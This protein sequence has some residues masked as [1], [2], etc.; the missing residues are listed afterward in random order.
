MFTFTDRYTFEW[1][2]R[3]KLPTADGEI[4]QEFTGE[5]LMPDDETDIFARV[6]AETATGMVEVARERLA[7]WWVGWSGITVEGGGELP[8][9]E[10]NRDRLLRQ[11]AVRIAVDAAL[12]EA[13]LGI[14]TQSVPGVREKN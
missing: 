3:V 1:P 6:D 2:V 12:S 9:S 5:F 4:V 14:P 13:V 10:E 8:F 7:K 11:R